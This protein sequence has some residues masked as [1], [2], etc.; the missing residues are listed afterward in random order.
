MSFNPNAI[1]L[2]KENP[3]KIDWFILSSNPNAIKLLKEN[4]EKINKI[5]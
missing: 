5:K 2:L 1:N 3:E 4:P